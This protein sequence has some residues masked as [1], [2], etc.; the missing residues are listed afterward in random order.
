M[1][2][3]PNCGVEVDDTLAQ[4]PLCG[5][6]LDG[7]GEEFDEDEAR[8]QTEPSEQPGPRARLWLW[9]V[10]TLVMGATA[11]I[12]GAADFAYGFDISWSIIPLCSLAFVWLFLTILI[13]LGRDIPLAY[14]AATLDTLAFLWMLA[15]VTS[16]GSWFS[17]LALPIT[18]LI[19]AVGGGAAAV[20][21]T[22]KLSVI[23]TIAD[24]VLAVGL[25][26]VGLQIILHFALDTESILSWSIVAFAGCV[27]IALLLLFINRRLRQ[28]H[29]DF[30]RV[31][32]L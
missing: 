2:Q 18:L 9:E 23:Q 4:C 12:V 16:G 29:A 19:A 7:Y 13:W 26:L 28:R 22:L 21:R 24:G 15:L 30:K 32:H 27:S 17:P 1:K 31:F 10:I 20:A 11:L 5:R 3:C 14:A 6:P 25:F 8:Q